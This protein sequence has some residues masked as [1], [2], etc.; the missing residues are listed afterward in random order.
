MS[1]LPRLDKLISSLCDNVLVSLETDGVTLLVEDDQ[2]RDLNYSVTLIELGSRL[3]FGVLECCP[4]HAR[5][6]LLE[7]IF[8][9][10]RAAEN[11]LEGFIALVQFFVN[12]G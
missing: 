2:G 8:I 6:V 7:V 5:E 12:F 3:V 1:L 11:D 9:S 4:W 10:V